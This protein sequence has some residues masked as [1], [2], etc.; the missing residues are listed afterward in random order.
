MIGGLAAQ[1]AH[2]KP[3]PF[4]NL[5][6]T[7]D[8][9]GKLLRV[10]TQNIDCLEERAGLSYGIPTWKERRGP[11]KTKRKPANAVA[12]SE[13]GLLTPPDAGDNVSSSASTSE[14]PSASSASPASAEESQPS[15]AP[16]APRC[17]P[18]HG[19][20]KTLYCPRCFHT[21]HLEPYLE[22]ISSGESIRCSSCEDFD[23]T[24]RLVGKR[25][26]GIG[27]LRPSVVLY[28]E[29]HREGE[30]IGECVRRDLLGITGPAWMTH[31]DDGPS[32]R[33]KSKAPASYSKSKRKP[34]LLIVAGTSLKIPGTKSMIRQFS[35][36]IRARNTPDEEDSDDA[37]E[38]D[39]A[40]RT[41]FVNLEFPV[42]SR[43]WNGLFDYWLQGDVQAFADLVKEQFERRD[44]QAKL[45]EAKKALR[46]SKKLEQE[47]LSAGSAPLTK[48]KQSGSFIQTPTKRVRGST[49]TPSSRGLPTPPPSVERSSSATMSMKWESDWDDA[50]ASTLVNA[51]QVRPLAPQTDPSTPRRPRPVASTAL[52]SP[53]FYI[54]VPPLRHSGRM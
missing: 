33:G 1:A 50:S 48:R 12:S 36:T 11:T 14:G 5:L 21:T 18:L 40:I 29:Q 28:G 37:S 13:S 41:I 43:E 27:H 42:P 32:R 38:E 2:T 9:R 49:S 7:L 22:R 3:T 51:A 47:L 44:S 34:D 16:V 39:D 46:A 23:S 4:H 17:I 54:D 24:R 19:H 8:E 30:I 15:A 20:V 10:Y 52:P 6:R 35:N 26:R 25:E 45:R 31:T 53:A